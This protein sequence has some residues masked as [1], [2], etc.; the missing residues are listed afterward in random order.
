MEAVTDKAVKIKD[1]KLMNSTDSMTIENVEMN[2]ISDDMTINQSWEPG[3]EYLIPK[4]SCINFDFKVKDQDFQNKQNYA[5]NIYLVIEYEVDGEDY[6]T[7]TL[8]TICESRYDSQTLYAIYKDGINMASY[9]NDY[10]EN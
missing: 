4:D 8:Q 1:I 6:I 7:S 3:G 5:V 2:I 10:V 9:F